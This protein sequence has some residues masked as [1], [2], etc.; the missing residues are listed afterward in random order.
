MKNKLSIFF[1][2]TSI[3]LAAG[4]S[5]K[6]PTSTATS[7]TAEYAKFSEDILE[8]INQHRRSRG[9]SALKI[10][11][12]IVAEAEK[13]SQQMATG[14]TAFGHAGFDARIS[15]ISNQ[16]GAA[17]KSAENVA[18][19]SR[20]ANEVVTGWLNSP[21]HRKNIEGDFNLTGIGIARNKKGV[22]Y[23]TQLFIKL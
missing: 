4:C 14:R 9:L 11:N 12:V 8:R 20:T 5:T 18:L 7:T 6:A 10:N 16:I 13:H 21:G 19:G 15:R 23:Y 3:V 1:I 17:R 22:L 2:C